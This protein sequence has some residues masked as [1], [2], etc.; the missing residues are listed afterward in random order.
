MAKQPSSSR[1]ALRAFTRLSRAHLV[2]Q[3]AIE[4]ALKA[5]GL[6]ALAWHDVLAELSV[7]PGQQLRPGDLGAA[8][9]AAQYNLSRLLDRM[10]AARLVRRI[11]VEGDARGQWVGLTPDGASTL[12]QTASIAGFAAEQSLAGQLDGDDIKKLS[13]L[14]RRIATPQPAGD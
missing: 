6:P 4:R 3:S 8:L 9:L 10:E 7:A 11:A 2:V 14:L 1:Q 12:V 5:A 13:K